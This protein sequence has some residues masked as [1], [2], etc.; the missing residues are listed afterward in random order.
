MRQ[1]EICILACGL[2]SLGC[3]AH[4]RAEQFLPASGIIEM[5]MS[6]HGEVL[7]RRQDVVSDG[8]SSAVVDA[9]S[10]RDWYPQA[11]PDDIIS[12]ALRSGGKHIL[13]SGRL[14]T[15][16][17]TG[18]EGIYE[19]GALVFPADPFVGKVWAR[20]QDGSLLQE[21]VVLAIEGNEVLLGEYWQIDQ[22]RD[23]QYKERW[24]KGEG[25]VELTDAGPPESVRYRVVRIHRKVTIPR[26]GRVGE[27]ETS[28]V[29]RRLATV[30]FGLQQL[31][32]AATA[33]LGWA[34]DGH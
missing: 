34:H 1:P 14:G 5:E 32:A 31:T 2:A 21:R 23:L 13:G 24:R 3:T 28:V 17:T 30:L 16:Y 6:G 20:Q 33:T 29:T 8:K 11:N 19:D 7:R 15:Y 9:T 18:A 10:L 22:R 4:L 25:R 27:H 12:E 26:Q